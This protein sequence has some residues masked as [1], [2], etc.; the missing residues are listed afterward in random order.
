MTLIPRQITIDDVILF[1]NRKWDFAP[2]ETIENTYRMEHRY[3]PTLTFM[4]RILEPDLPPH[5]VHRLFL[6]PLEIYHLYRLGEAIAKQA[7]A[8]EI[9]GCSMQEFKEFLFL[10]ILPN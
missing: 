8:M 2:V 3:R 10:P 7:G 1:F 9:M 4:L 5:E 6:S